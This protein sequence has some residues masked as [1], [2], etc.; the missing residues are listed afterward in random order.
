MPEPPE[1]TLS[2]PADE[3]VPVQ[4]QNSTAPIPRAATSAFPFEAAGLPAGSAPE[5]GERWKAIQNQLLQDGQMTLYLFS[6]PASVSFCGGELHLIFSEKDSVN[7]QELGEP[8]NMKLLRSA[9]TRIMGSDTR[10][11]VRLAGDPQ[12]EAQHCPVPDEPAWISRVR[13]AADA[14]HIPIKME[15]Q[16][17][18]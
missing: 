14:F 6:R 15:E 3:P 9:A 18:G 4:A 17:N 13:E 5:D 1:S 2:E 10:V 8:H 12:I 16:E 11:V 7:C